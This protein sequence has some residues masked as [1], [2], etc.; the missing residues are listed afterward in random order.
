VAE[1]LVGAVHEVDDDGVVVRH[2]PPI[3]ADAAT[4]V[5]QA[6]S[7]SAVRAPTLARSRCRG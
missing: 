2:V 3:I 1:Q 4:E 7:G 6:V 5:V